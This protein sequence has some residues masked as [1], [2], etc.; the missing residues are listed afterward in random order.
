MIMY[1]YEFFCLKVEQIRLFN[2][3]RLKTLKLSTLIFSYHS[4]SQ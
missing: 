2:V 3:F 1:E 4:Y